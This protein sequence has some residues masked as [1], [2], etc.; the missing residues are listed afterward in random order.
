MCEACGAKLALLAFE[1]MRHFWL[2]FKHCVIA[3][4][5]AWKRLKKK[6][7]IAWDTKNFSLQVYRVINPCTALFCYDCAKKKLLYCIIAVS[8]IIQQH[9]IFVFFLT[10]VLLHIKKS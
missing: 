3:T 4:T 10:L 6:V 9:V 2:V 5:E 7:L 1:E 8:A